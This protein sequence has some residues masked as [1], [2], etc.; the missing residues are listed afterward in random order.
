MSVSNR[1]VTRGREAATA[2]TL[3]AATGLEATTGPEVAKL[4]P[5]PSFEA[6]G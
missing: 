1:A 5:S 2:T 3:E 6:A 4:E